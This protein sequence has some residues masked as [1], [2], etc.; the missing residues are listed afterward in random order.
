[1]RHHNLSWLHPQSNSKAFRRILKVRE[2]K[3]IS[4]H[5]AQNSVN[6]ILLPRHRFHVYYTGVWV[7]RGRPVVCR[8]VNR[9]P[10]EPYVR[11]RNTGAVYRTGGHL[12]L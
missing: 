2:E 9:R 6:H 1:M 10:Y 7:C 8:D 3:M 12:E 11:H 5:T 4:Q